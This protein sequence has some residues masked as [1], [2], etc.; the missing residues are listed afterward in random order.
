MMQQT[1]DLLPTATQHPEAAAGRVTLYDQS[2]HSAGFRDAPWELTRSVIAR[3]EPVGSVTVCYLRDL[4]EMDEG[5][6]LRSERSLLTALAQRLGDFIQ[7]SR[8]QEQLLAYQKSLRS[9][10]AQ[11]SVTEQRERRR[12][13]EGLHDRIG[14]SLALISIRLDEARHNAGDVKLRTMLAEIQDMTAEVIKETRT[15]T[16]DLC[17]PILHELG[18]TRAVEWLATHFQ[19]TYGLDVRVE[20]RGDVGDVCEETRFLL[21]PAVRE[22]LT[23]VVKHAGAHEVLVRIVGENGKIR[24]SV[25]DDGVGLDRSRM[26]A[27]LNGQEGFGLFNIREHVTYMGGTVEM[28]SKPGEGTEVVLEADSHV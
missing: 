9:L 22:L 26:S 18:L 27:C 19:T 21:F 24:V 17:P 16:F 4:P 12:L 20:K 3:G 15:L 5:P 2:W 10:A 1:V 25:K 11:L 28:Y 23:N 8:A 13:A 6:F 14:Q 7:Q